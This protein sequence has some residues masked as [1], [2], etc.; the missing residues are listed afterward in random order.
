MMT[1][2][3][4]SINDYIICHYVST[5]FKV[6]ELLILHFVKNTIHSLKNKTTRHECSVLSLSHS[7]EESQPVLFIVY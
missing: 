4:I 3:F 6:T 7:I 5:Q 2:G 1:S